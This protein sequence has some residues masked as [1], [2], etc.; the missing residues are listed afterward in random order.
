VFGRVHKERLLLDLR[1]VFPEQDAQLVE[2]VA[3]IRSGTSSQE[4]EGDLSNGE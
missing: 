1:S 3:E 2:A 4:P